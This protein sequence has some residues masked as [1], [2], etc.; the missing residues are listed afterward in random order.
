MSKFV[1][2]FSFFCVFS[3]GYELKLSSNVTAL[4]LLEQDLYIGTDRGEILKYNI[5][6]KSLK[7]LL[8][9]PSIKNYH[10][11]SF[12]SIYSIDV[13]GNSLLILSE[14]DFGAKNLGFY[15]KNLQLKKLENSSIKKAYFLDEN[16]FIL[17][18]FGSELYLVDKNLKELSKFIF[19]HSSL[20]DAVLNESKTKLV[21]GFESGEVELFDLQNWKVLKIR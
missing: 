15:N 1:L 18:S 4:K 17:A 9:L 2:I 20:N 19:S 14:G 16:T 3:F 12:A 8:S 21:A 5:K 13:L 7:K 6:D 10:E 11:N